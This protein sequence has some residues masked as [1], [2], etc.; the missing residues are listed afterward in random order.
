MPAMNILA[1]ECACLMWYEC[2]LR[3]HAQGANASFAPSNPVRL[4]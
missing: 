3:G 2:A 4:G 1:R